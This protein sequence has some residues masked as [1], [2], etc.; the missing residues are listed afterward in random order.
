MDKLWYSCNSFGRLG[1]LILNIGLLAFQIKVQIEGKI[2]S[3]VNT[4]YMAISF[5]NFLIIALSF[6]KTYGVKFSYYA[7]ILSLLRLALRWLD[8]EN[9]TKVISDS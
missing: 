6:K 5:I 7:T 1:T 9:S 4:L 2:K 8:L 3:Q